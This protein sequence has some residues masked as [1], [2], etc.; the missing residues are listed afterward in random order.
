MVGDYPRVWRKNSWTTRQTPSQ[1]KEK[2][3]QTQ[4]G[5]GVGRFQGLDLFSVEL[6][7]GGD[8]PLV[9]VELLEAEAI[10]PCEDD[11]V[12]GEGGL[13]N[14]GG[15]GR[16]RRFLTWCDFGPLVGGRVS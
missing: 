14:L 8:N 6:H 15:G 2:E 4:L 16:R 12:V 1:R 7:G 11:V 10:A 9:V 5:V 13:K 3:S